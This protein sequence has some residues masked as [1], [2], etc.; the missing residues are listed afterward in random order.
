MDIGPLILGS[1]DWEQT[2]GKIT[3]ILISERSGLGHAILLTKRKMEWGAKKE[4]EADLKEGQML[5]S[6]LV[7]FFHADRVGRPWDTHNFWNDACGRT[8]DGPS[9]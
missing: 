1:Q 4:Q 3:A 2:K 7:R 6:V 9:A 5:T 8:L